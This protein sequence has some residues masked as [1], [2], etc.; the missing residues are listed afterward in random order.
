MARKAKKIESVKAWA[1]YVKNWVGGLPA[2]TCTNKYIAQYVARDF[3]ERHGKTNVS[4]IP[5]LIVPIT[6]PRKARKSK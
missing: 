4:I 1:V 6:K 5:V 2:T 3:I